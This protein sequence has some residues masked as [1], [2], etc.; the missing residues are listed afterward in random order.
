[1]ENRAVGEFERLGLH[2]YLVVDDF[3]QPQFREQFGVPKDQP[4]PFPV[5]A[6]LRE[7]GGTTV[8]DLGSHPAAASPVAL[9]PGSAPR[10]GA[11]RV[12]LR[13]R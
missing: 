4:L 8:F 12:P 10:C 5:V 7:S 9:E 6:R 1:M 2:P 13:V 11:P 3:E